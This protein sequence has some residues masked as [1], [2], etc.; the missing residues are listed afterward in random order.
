MRLFRASV[1]GLLAVF[2]QS[3][4]LSRLTDR[5]FV[6][7]TVKRPTYSDR[8]TTGLVLLPIT[9]ALDVATF[10]IQLILLA[11]AGDNFIL[12]RDDSDESYSRKMPGY[13]VQ[14]ESNPAFQKLSAEQQ[15]TAI[16]EFETLVAS[17]ALDPT[18]ALG[19]TEDG[20]WMQV[21]LTDEARAQLLERSKAKQSRQ[22]L[23][24]CEP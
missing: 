5:A 23:A 13:I 21:P 4:I 3:C 12:G 24:M 16:T 14:L 10:P 7:F 19:L 22:A 15:Q 20:H 2:A 11:I 17:G 6:G 18:A 9:F 1:V 8:K